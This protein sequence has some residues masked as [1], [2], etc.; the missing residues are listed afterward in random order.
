LGGASGRPIALDALVEKSKPLLDT[1][2]SISQPQ[3]H[4][5]TWTNYKGKCRHFEKKAGDED[6]EWI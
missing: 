3:S 5:T 1:I 2:P 4:F 6:E